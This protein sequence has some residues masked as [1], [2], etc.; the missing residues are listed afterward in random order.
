VPTDLEQGI[1]VDV[2][3]EWMA[4]GARPAFLYVIPE[5]H[6]PLGVAISPER[7][8]RLVELARHYGLPIVE[9]DPYAF[10]CYDGRPAPPLRALNDQWVFY[11]GSFSKILAPAVRLGWLVAPES[12]VPKL[13]VIKEA[14]DL[15]SS[16]FIQ[17]TVAGFLD[18]GHLPG[19]LER[20]CAA[21]GQRRSAMLA[22]LERYFPAG[23]RWSRPK[24]GMFIWV[25]LPEACSAA[26]LLETALDEEK[27]AFIPGHAFGVRKGRR[28]LGHFHGESG[29]AHCMRLNFSNCPVD[30]IEDGIRRLGRVVNAVL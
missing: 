7:R 11:V 12:L 10:L 21:Y 25:E 26:R 9:D 27:V 18:A 22:A 30:G 20:L 8:Y 29:A 2:V 28:H 14:I 19:H 6:N 15:E 5:A 16:A 3:E 13:T 24:G 1:D 4:G 17:R 23:A